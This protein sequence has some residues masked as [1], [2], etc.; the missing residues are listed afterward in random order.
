MC[1]EV[2]FHLTWIDLITT[3]E[4]S[5]VCQLVEGEPD[6]KNGQENLI[7]ASFHGQ[8]QEH[9]SIVHCDLACF[10]IIG[11]GEERERERREGKAKGVGGG[12]A[13]P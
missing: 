5:V 4:N 7:E 6:K 1:L 3:Y 2:N 8:T 11:A 10:E 12:A 9:S 13:Q